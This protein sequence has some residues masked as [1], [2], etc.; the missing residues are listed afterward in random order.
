MKLD[1]NLLTAEERVDYVNSL[2]KN[3]SN[4]SPRQLDKLSDYIL[5]VGESITVKQREEEYPMLTKNREVTLGRRETSLDSTIDNLPGG[6][7]SLWTV[8]SSSDYPLGVKEPLTM[9]HIDDIPGGPQK[10]AAIETLEKQLAKASGFNKFKLKKAIIEMWQDLY[11]ARIAHNAAA[12]FATTPKLAPTLKGAGHIELPEHFWLAADGTPKSDSDF[13]L[14]EPT[15]VLLLLRHYHNLK[16]EI[17]DNLHCDMH[18]FLWELEAISRRALANSPVLLDLCRL[19]MLGYTGAE[20]VDYMETYHNISHSEQYFS[21]LWT[22]K[23]PKLISEE[24]K[25]TFLVYYWRN[26]KGLPFKTC[27]TC[28]KTFPAHPYF[29]HRNTSSDGFYS[30]CKTCR[31]NN[32]KK[33]SSYVQDPFTGRVV[34]HRLL[35]LGYAPDLERG[36]YYGD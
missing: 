11:S 22:K 16:S 14:F 24:A 9:K 7:D 4:L 27:S 12:G 8:A 13:S 34:E 26:H 35:S 3:S 23:I 28:K 31:K 2:L 36:E 6:E 15:I 21:T 30:K 19:E 29:F 33:Q 20:I 18:Y 10:L 1:Y 25:K 32:F 17:A 5:F